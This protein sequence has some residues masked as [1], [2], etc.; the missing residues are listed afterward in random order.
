MSVSLSILKSSVPSR[1][2][3]VLTVFSLFIVSSA[4]A[5]I[6]NNTG[7]QAFTGVESYR[8]AS[9]DL[10][11]ITVFEEP[12]FGISQRVS[13]SGDISMPLLGQV[14]IGGL[15]VEEAQRQIELALIE[16]EFL[17]QPQVFVSIE[18]FS[19]RR[20][21]ILGEIG[22]PT[23]IEL[24]PGTNSFDIEVVIA[25]AGGFSDLARRSEVRVTRKS[26]EDGIER[27]LKVDVDKVMHD[28]KNGIALTRFRVLPGDI[29]FV[30]RRFF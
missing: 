11:R 24:P 7:Q 2:G 22:S 19:P 9:F 10:V 17:R 5:E 4:G 14:R 21:T 6:Q 13:A 23:S 15:T 3:L 1:L 18:G 30:P 20:I 28:E 26:A 8:L 25:M 27:V 29:L 16:Q 12:E